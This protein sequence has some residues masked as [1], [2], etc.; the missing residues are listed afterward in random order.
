[1]I[2]LS[3]S[4]Y[5]AML[6]LT[7]MVKTPTYWVKTPNRHYDAESEPPVQEKMPHPGSEN[8]LYKTGM[9]KILPY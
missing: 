7:R 8:I 3:R 4:E 5:N 9:L 2:S 6:N 1:M